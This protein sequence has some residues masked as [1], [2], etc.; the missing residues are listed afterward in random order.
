[1]RRSRSLCLSLGVLLLGAC[2]Q[3]R[4]HARA[5]HPVLPQIQQVG[6]GSLGGVV[7][8]YLGEPLVG[9]RIE[10]QQT[11]PDGQLVTQ[12]NGRGQYLFR[13]LPGGSYAVTVVANNSRKAVVLPENAKFRANIRIGPT[14]RRIVEPNQ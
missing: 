12:T 5:S 14:G 10:L 6:E 4:R 7:V 1:M 9:A 3:G 8:N 11:N 2:S 13:G